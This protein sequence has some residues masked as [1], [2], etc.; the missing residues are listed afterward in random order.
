MHG[1][2]IFILII[3]IVS[4]GLAAYFEYQFLTKGNHGL[5]KE[6]FEDKIYP[7]I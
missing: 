4:L 1:F 7:E 2:V 6:M 3:W 5:K